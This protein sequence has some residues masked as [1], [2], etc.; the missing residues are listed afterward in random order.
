MSLMLF[1][2][3]P[4]QIVEVVVGGLGVVENCGVALVSL[5]AGLL[6]DLQGCMLDL[7]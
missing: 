1:D 2:D 4:V 7:F 3:G 5:A 6:A